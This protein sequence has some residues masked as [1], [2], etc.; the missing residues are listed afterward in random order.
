M[1]LVA[2]VEVPSLAVAVVPFAMEPLA[3][4]VVGAVVPLAALV[5]LAVVAA[6][7]LPVAATNPQTGA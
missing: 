3:A 1:L 2:A 4:V 6:M 7:A 5:V